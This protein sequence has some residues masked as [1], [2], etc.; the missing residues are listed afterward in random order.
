M[1]NYCISCGMPLSLKNDIAKEIDKGSLC[2]YCVQEDGTV[3]S[4]EEIFKG[5]VQFFMSSVP[6]VDKE[7]AERV[8]RKNMKNQPYWQDT[9]N[10]CLNGLE[11][12]DEE[13]EMVLTKL[14]EGQET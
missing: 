11:A 2:Q 5:G 9:E 1:K 12:T 6:G 7:L 13:F 4:C 14:H 10:A 8:T 3:K